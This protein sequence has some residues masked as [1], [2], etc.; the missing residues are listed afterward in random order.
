MSVAHLP[1]RNRGDLHVLEAPPEDDQPTPEPDTDTAAERA[2]LGAI[3]RDPQALDQATQTVT[4]QDLWRPQHRTIYDAAVALYSRGRP[5]DTITVANHLGPDQLRKAG[6]QAYLE[7]LT[8]DAIAVIDVT[9]YAHIVAGHAAARRLREHHQRG[10]Q[11]LTLR[12]DTPIADLY[13]RTADD[14]NNIP[15]GVPGVDQAGP[16]TSWDDVDIADVLANGEPD[17]QPTHLARTDGRMLLYPQAVHSISGEPES[18]KTWIA[19][20]AV[21]Q[22]LEAGEH[23]LYID[24]EDRASRVIGRL[25]TIGGRP[26]HLTAQFHYKRPL[27]ALDNL[28]RGRLD[29]AARQSTLAVI[30]GVTEAMTLHGLSLL[31]NEDAARYLDL[32]PRHIA[33]LGP[34]V[35]QI[36]HVVKDPEKQ[37]RWA[38]GASHKLAG[39]D[40]AA[41]TAKVAQAFGKGQLGRCRISV[42]KDRPGGVRE[43]AVGNL[44]GEFILDART[45]DA[46]VAVLEPPDAMQLNDAGELR[47][48]HLMERISRYVE[49][50]P[51]VTAKGIEDVINGKATYVRIAVRTL[52]AEGYINVVP[53]PRGAQKHSSIIPFRET[54]DADR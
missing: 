40:G 38:I 5:V 47:P 16:P 13:Q 18:G 8:I 42:N 29:E 31:D 3:L 54:D 32:L 25:L 19:L 37:G 7:Q 11:D 4:S 17:P 1:P 28:T 45:P 9:Y 21:R 2:V 15:R 48:T 34:A 6:G 49:I 50:T 51:G 36:D 24:F 26:D 53:G 41:Y 46:T 33:D 52:I 20:L 30:D 12:G 43:H 22:A 10:L 39:L 23:V 27:T 44:V 14:L 35:L